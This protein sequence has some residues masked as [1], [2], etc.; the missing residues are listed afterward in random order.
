M[1]C[2]VL[3][4]FISFSW[5]DAIISISL[6]ATAITAY[7]ASA[8]SLSRAQRIKNSCITGLAI[9]EFVLGSLAILVFIITFAVVGVALYVNTM[10]HTSLFVAIRNIDHSYILLNIHHRT[11]GSHC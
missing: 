10:L 7:N 6:G 9:A 11:A 5:I 3:G 8:D 1:S 2:R 4:L